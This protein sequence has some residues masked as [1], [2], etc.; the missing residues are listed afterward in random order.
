MGLIILNKLKLGNLVN[1]MNEI[2]GWPTE[3][4]FVTNKTE[5]NTKL[6][7]YWK[8]GHATDEIKKPSHFA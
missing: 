3:I 5:A 7:D 2:E 8:N 1:L 6:T 4:E